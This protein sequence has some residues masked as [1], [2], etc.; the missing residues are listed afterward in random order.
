MTRARKRTNEAPLTEP[1]KTSP[2]RI[3]VEKE[4]TVFE[5]GRGG[6][7][8]GDRLIELHVNGDRHDIAAKL[9]FLADVV[10]NTWGD[11]IESAEILVLFR[12]AK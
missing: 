2:I 8:V 9:R 7:P 4:S 3:D 1:R 6:G 10:A 12:S 5:G 11:P